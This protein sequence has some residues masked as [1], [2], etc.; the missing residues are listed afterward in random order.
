MAEDYRFTPQ[1]VGQMTLYQVRTLM[2]DRK[3]LGAGRYRI[4]PSEVSIARTKKVGRKQMDRDREWNKA[5]R[6]R[7]QLRIKERL[8]QMQQDAQQKRASDAQ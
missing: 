6:E 2:V 8:R 4:G 7:Y 5:K 3:Q 1:Q